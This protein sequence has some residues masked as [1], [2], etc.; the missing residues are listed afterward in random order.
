MNKTINTNVTTSP[1]I[2]K[3][4]LIDG[5]MIDGHNLQ[6]II[7]ARVSSSALSPWEEQ[8]GHSCSDKHK[9]QSTKFSPQSFAKW[10]LRCRITWKY[11]PHLPGLKKTWAEKLCCGEIKET[12][13]NLTNPVSIRQE[14]M[15]LQQQGNAPKEINLSLMWGGAVLLQGTLF[16]VIPN[17]LKHPFLLILTQNSPYLFAFLK[18][19]FPLCGKFS[20][21]ETM[22]C[23]MCRWWEWILLKNWK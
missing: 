15:N 8:R 6:R 12:K 7:L 14:S 23:W 2:R 17:M 13:Q 21:L 4:C 1:F 3:E 11:W 10:T 18:T 16:K 9:T 19:V 5:I 22:F 20:L